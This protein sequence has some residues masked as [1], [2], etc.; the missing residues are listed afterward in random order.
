MRIFNPS[1]LTAFSKELAEIVS[2]EPE[3]AMIMFV[4]E[5][6]FKNEINLTKETLSVALL[7]II[8]S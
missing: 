4:I 7:K 3:A 1:P 2:I 5:F 8:I 6:E